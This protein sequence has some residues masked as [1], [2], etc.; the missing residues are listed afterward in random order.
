MNYKT[1]K[2][3]SQNMLYININIVVTWKGVAKIGKEHVWCSG[4]LAMFN[5]LSRMVFTL[6][7][8]F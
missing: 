5:F 6:V 7:S 3:K 4:F 8:T 1:Y 2:K